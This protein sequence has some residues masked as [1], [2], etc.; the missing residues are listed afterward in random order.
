MRNIILLVSSNQEKKMLILNEFH[1]IMDF[2]YVK[3]ESLFNTINETIE[4]TI[5]QEESLKF[6]NTYIE[7][8][9]KNSSIYIIDINECKEEI[10]SQFVNSEKLITITL[11][12]NLNYTGA[13]KIDLN[14]KL[15]EQLENIRKELMIADE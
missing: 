11:D 9:A 2:S 7:K 5:N 13:I 1:K 12:D 4:R 6:F 15:K 8:I 10:L 14:N 3:L